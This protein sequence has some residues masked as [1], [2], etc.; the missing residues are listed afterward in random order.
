MR[1][2][3]HLDIHL[4]LLTASHSQ[5]AQKTH[6]DIHLKLLTASYSQDAQKNPFRYS[7]KVTYSKL[8]SRCA[9]KPI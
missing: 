5:D 1:I 2:K 9:Q 4:Q 3:T 7:P 8:L 6:L